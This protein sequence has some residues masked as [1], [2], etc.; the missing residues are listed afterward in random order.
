MRGHC[1]TRDEPA[2]ELGTSLLLPPWF[3]EQR[4][5]IVAM[6]EP[7]TVPEGNL[8][9]GAK[10]GAGG[11]P[12]VETAAEKAANASRRAAVFVKPEDK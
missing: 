9:K 12:V 1:S 4:P 11:V 10:V 8:P 2:D 3:E 7:V 6:L 5:A